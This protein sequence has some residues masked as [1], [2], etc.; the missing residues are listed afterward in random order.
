MAPMPQL[1]DLGG[2]P[3]P[4]LLTLP[5]FTLQRIRY[6]FH[7]A[8]RKDFDS[9]LYGSK[10]LPLFN[11]RRGCM[12][13]ALLHIKMPN[14]LPSV[15]VDSSFFFPFPPTTASSIIIP[16]TETMTISAGSGPDGVVTPHSSGIRV[17]VVGLG[18]A[19]ITAAVECH[20]KGHSVIVVDKVQSI[21]PHGDQIGVGANAA[22]V[23][24]KWRNGE[25]FKDVLPF[26]H[27]IKAMEM[28]D[29]TGKLYFVNDTVGFHPPDGYMVNRGELV[30]LMYEYAQSLGI[31]IRLGQVV[32]EYWES[33]TEAGIIVNGERLAA[34][35]VIAC[36]GVH[37]KAR[38]VVL[39]EDVAP[40]PTGYS[41]FRAY[42]DSN[43]LADD[44]QAN[45][46]LEGTENRDR[47]QVFAREGYLLLVYTGRL[48]KD[49]GWMLT[50]E[51][52][53][54]ASESWSTSVDPDEAIR[55]LQDWPVRDRIV[56][57]VR[58]TPKE[59]LI[60][61]QLLLRPPLPTWVSGKGRIL[62]IGDAAHPNFHTSGQGAAQGIEDAATVAIALEL[63]GKAG[64]P[65]A[66]LTMEKIRYQRATII[67]SS[68]LQIQDSLRF[69]KAAIEKDP[70]RARIPRPRWIFD[71]D[72][73]AYAYQHFHAAAQAVQ[74]GEEYHPRNIPV[75][76]EYQLVHD[77]KGLKN[78]E[79]M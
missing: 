61:F 73:Q 40:D 4:T 41:M 50:H 43:I 69:D 8:L 18:I 67:Q 60:D 26:I 22:R 48:G 9:L 66:L 62:L 77:F 14:F 11:C 70:T 23:L 2:H 58:H 74:S 68:G 31:D 78:T 32:S 37:G 17:I 55:I 12:E 59:K 7:G 10:T 39:G 19:G 6:A 53:R 44:P 30:R 33:A 13:Q 36:D 72:C 75:G 20:R 34:D 25:F 56:P 42:F 15:S 46:I 45:W 79:S 52:Y 63:A 1:H 76:G 21:R 65:L 54:G 3:T 35:C 71:H 28:H 47:S 64:V 38:S 51:D 24:G 57:I 5:C 29:D 16:Q 49:V 27:H